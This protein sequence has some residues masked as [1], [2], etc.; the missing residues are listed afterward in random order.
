MSPTVS[1]FKIPEQ[2]P[3]NY[4]LISQIGSILLQNPA[5]LRGFSAGDA[6]LHNSN[7]NTRTAPK[8]LIPSVLACSGRSVKDKWF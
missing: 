3:I 2:S 4:L 5:N 8:S 6:T 1:N 7:P